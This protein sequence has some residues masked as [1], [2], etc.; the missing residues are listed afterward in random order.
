MKIFLIAFD[1]ISQFS[2]KS[3]I[4]IRN[5]ANNTIGFRRGARNFANNAIGFCKGVRNFANNAIAFRAYFTTLP[6][7]VSLLAGT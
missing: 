3:Q 2:Q 5:F 6:I 7:R 1:E 4:A